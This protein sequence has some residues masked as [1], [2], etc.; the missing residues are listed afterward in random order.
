MNISTKIKL[1][2]PFVNIKTKNDLELQAPDGYSI[3]HKMELGIPM[4]ELFAHAG[5]MIINV[6]VTR[7]VK[8]RNVEID[9]IALTI[10]APDELEFLS[11]DKNE[12]GKTY[13][14]MLKQSLEIMGY[15]I[16][17]KECNETVPCLK[18]KTY[19]TKLNLE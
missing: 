1:N 6:P 18:P 7:V 15:K 10:L 12:A 19:R 13:R 11:G 9:G 17:S 5:I 3:T 14:T 4:K 16:K 8:G 2:K